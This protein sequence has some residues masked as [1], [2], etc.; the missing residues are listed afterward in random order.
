MFFSVNSVRVN[1]VVSLC[2]KP[3]RLLGNIYVLAVS[4]MLTLLKRGVDK[5]NADIYII[6]LDNYSLL[7][8]DILSNVEVGPL[9]ETI[10]LHFDTMVI[11]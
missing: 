9:I 2:Q 3:M 5:G 7:V 1:K 11:S 6:F 4:N 10:F 8:L